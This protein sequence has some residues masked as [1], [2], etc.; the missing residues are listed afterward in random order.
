VIKKRRRLKT[1]RKKCENVAER[2]EAIGKCNKPGGDCENQTQWC[3][4]DKL[5]EKVEKVEK[6]SRCRDYL[7]CNGKRKKPVPMPHE[8][9]RDPRDFITMEKLTYDKEFGNVQMAIRCAQ[10]IV[11]TNRK[12]LQ[13]LQAKVDEGKE[14]YMMEI[15]VCSG[16]Q[17]DKKN[18]CCL[19]MSHI[20]AGLDT[21]AKASVIGEHEVEKI[22][23][24]WLQ[25]S[26]SERLE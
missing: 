20:L 16:A 23:L 12:D 5:G 1:S 26:M 25:E 6:K 2:C 11:E 13:K 7:R 24:K 19:V 9:F 22:E 15:G 4:C 10:V 21:Q 14:A 3:Q 18:H 17:F 8:R